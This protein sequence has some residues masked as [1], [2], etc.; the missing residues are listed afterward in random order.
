[1][2][3]AHSTRPGV[4]RTAGEPVADALGEVPQRVVGTVVFE[5]LALQLAHLGGSGVRS[6]GDGREGAKAQAGRRQRR[7]TESCHEETSVAE[8][9]IVADR[10]R[11][12]ARSRAAMRDR[13]TAA[14]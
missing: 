7:G 11:W 13:A 10:L 14:S 12:R 8:E 9:R 6:R 1:V 4:A 3:S 2:A 5:R